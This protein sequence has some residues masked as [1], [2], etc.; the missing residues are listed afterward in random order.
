MEKTIEYPL[1][2]LQSLPDTLPADG[3]IGI[4]L[5]NG[6]PVIRASSCVQDRIEVLLDKQ[7]KGGLSKKELDEF[8]R[9]EELDDYLSFINRVTRNI[10]LTPQN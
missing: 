1:P 7:K 10:F 5:Q 6:I 2:K 3:A 4:E 9:Y 8:D